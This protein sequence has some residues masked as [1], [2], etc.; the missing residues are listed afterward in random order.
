M[1]LLIYLHYLYTMILWAFDRTA[2]E[3]VVRSPS[4]RYHAILTQ[5]KSPAIPPLWP[6]PHIGFKTIGQTCT[7]INANTDKKQESIPSKETRYTRYIKAVVYKL[8][9]RNIKRN[10]RGHQ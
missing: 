6:M 7:P 1:N 10:M 5:S 4:H 3:V 2:R 9:N 8:K